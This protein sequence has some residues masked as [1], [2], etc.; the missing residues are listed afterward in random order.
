MIRQT[1]QLLAASMIFFASLTGQSIAQSAEATFRVNQLEEQVRQLNG[2]IE[3]LNFQLL[4]LQ[5]T[6]RKLQEDN[7][8]R[9]Q[10]LEDRSDAKKSG[11]NNS[12]AK[13][14][15]RD[16]GSDG[17]GSLGKQQPSE[18]AI[19]VDDSDGT[20]RG[21]RRTID[22][23]EIFDGSSDTAAAGPQPLGKILF[24]ENGNIVDSS[25]EAPI[26][27]TKRLRGAGESGSSEPIPKNADELYSLGYNYIQSGDYALAE[28]AFR[29]FIDGF[30]AHPRVTRSLFLAWR[31][32]FCPR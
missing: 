7:E 6:L 29:K 31:K 10:E 28:G 9:F 30:P 21:K 16:N 11:S 25:L 13:I 1:C 19:I 27:L 14:L 26:D 23:V 22:G 5:E 24:D 8:F 2:R 18:S 15:D 20:K 3:D 17:G 32:S 12:I 4:Q